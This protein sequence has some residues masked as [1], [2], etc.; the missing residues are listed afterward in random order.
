MTA[1]RLISPRLWPGT[2]QTLR[3]WHRTS[4]STQDG[5]IRSI[6]DASARLMNSDNGLLPAVDFVGILKMSFQ[7]SSV[8]DATKIEPVLPL[9]WRQAHF[10]EWR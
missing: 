10:I 8:W 2:R 7:T 4:L 6:R 9:A 5:V 3:F 1:S